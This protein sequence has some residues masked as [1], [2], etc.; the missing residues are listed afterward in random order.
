MSQIEAIVRWFTT[1]VLTINSLNVH[2]SYVHLTG[3]IAQQSQ[4]LQVI[5]HAHPFAVRIIMIQKTT[6]THF[7]TIFVIP[8]TAHQQSYHLEPF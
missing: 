7:L 8:Q 1:L 5:I 6:K 4:E 3:K 2:K